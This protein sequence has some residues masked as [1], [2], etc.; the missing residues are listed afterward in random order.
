MPRT[1]SLMIAA[2]VALC[3]LAGCG[4]VPAAPSVFSAPQ[5]PIARAFTPTPAL[6]DNMQPTQIPPSQSATPVPIAAQAAPAQAP[7]SAATPAQ[8]EPLGRSI[9]TYL[10]DIVRAGWFQ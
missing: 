6:A 9:D 2:L 3:M 1:Y 10:N 5:A 4:G 8:L 7:I